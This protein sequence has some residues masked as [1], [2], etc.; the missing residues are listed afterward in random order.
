MIETFKKVYPDVAL[1][2]ANYLPFTDS[3]GVSLSNCTKRNTLFR[4]MW[5][6]DAFLVKVMDEL[7]AYD[8]AFTCKENDKYLGRGRA[9]VPKQMSAA[10]LTANR[11]ID[12]SLQ[13]S[14]MA[15]IP[16][17]DE[18]VRERHKELD[19]TFYAEL[20]TTTGEAVKP[21]SIQ[22]NLRTAEWRMELEGTAGDIA[23]RLHISACDI[24]SR[25][26]GGGQRTATEINKESDMTMKLANKK[27][28]LFK[29]SLMSL[30]RDLLEVFG[31]DRNMDCY[32]EY[33]SV[34]LS[35]PQVATA[36][37]TQQVS[38]RLLSKYTA[39]KK[40]NPEMSEK[41]IQEELVR[42]EQDS[43]MGA[44]IDTDDVEM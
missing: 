11:R 10:A 28:E 3:L 38:A 36:V 17:S 19:K 30:V 16:F 7:Y 6:G 25:L 1:F 13:R 39:L 37:I 4:S 42:I 35:N 12:L 20:S 14:S 23:A 27:R 15:N 18:Q 26:N 21:T 40:L 44:E 22:F 34:G 43:M 32:I 29:A 24:D 8:H 5:F 2:K 41:E 9:L 31:Y 33:P